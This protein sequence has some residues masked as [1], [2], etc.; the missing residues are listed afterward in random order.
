MTCRE[1][2][3]FQMTVKEL[4]MP[5]DVFH[6][7]LEKTLGRS[8]WTHELGLNWEGIHSE[9]WG[10]RPAPTFEEIMNLIPAGKR[11]VIGL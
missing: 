11:I 4:S 5:F 3:E 6:E 10:E 8:V 9:L 1:R 2:A 7:A